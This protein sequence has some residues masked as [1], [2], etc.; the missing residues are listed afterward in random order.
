[1]AK[2]RRPPQIP[3]RYE[4]KYL[5]PEQLTWA[6]REAILPFCRLDKHAEQAPDHQYAICSLYLDTPQR[7]FHQAKVERQ[8]KRL[9]LRVRTYGELADGPVFFEVKRKVGD[10]VRKNRALVPREDWMRRLTE[11]LPADASGAERDFRAVMDS[12]GALPTLLVRYHREAYAS[13]VDDY[14]RVTFDRRLCFQRM[15]KLQLLGTT[16]SWIALDDQTNTHGASRQ[17]ILELKATLAVPRWMLG[18]VQRFGLIRTGFSKYCNGVER[19]WGSS[20][21]LHFG[22]RTAVW[23]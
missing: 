3:M 5:V 13:V 7:E 16:G 6:L 15:D 17:V 4:A 20:N 18:I 23:G 1:M 21:L 11:L 10:L 12:K 19:L 9:K 8:Q 14:A 22:D 2:K